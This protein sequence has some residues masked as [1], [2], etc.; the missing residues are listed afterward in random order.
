MRTDVSQAAAAALAE[1]PEHIDRLEPRKKHLTQ[2]DTIL[3]LRLA[4]EG[5][6]QTQIAQRLAVSQP[7]ISDLLNKFT[8]T[9]ELAKA[10]LN[11]SSY[12]LA[13]RAIRDADVDQSLEMLD[14]LGV[15]EKRQQ[16]TGQTGISI[17]IGQQTAV[18]GQDPLEVLTAQHVTVKPTS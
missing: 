6:N 3:A 11:G 13:E 16:Q 1:H 4:S 12:K 8:D 14:R 18:T 5:L 10:R 17:Y 7:T 15:A 9:R 2:T